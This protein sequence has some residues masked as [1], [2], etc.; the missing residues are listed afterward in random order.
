MTVPTRSE[1]NSIYSQDA[2][3]SRSEGTCFRHDLSHGEVQ[4]HLRETN[5]RLNS[6]DKTLC[7]V[8][9]NQ[10]ANLTKGTMKMNLGSDRAV[11]RS[12]CNAMSTGDVVQ[13]NGVRQASKLVRAYETTQGMA[14]LSPNG[15]G[16]TLNNDYGNL[17]MINPHTGRA[18][19]IK[20]YAK[21]Q[22]SR[23]LRGRG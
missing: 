14:E 8:A 6:Y 16:S 20:N 7:A 22:K 21:Q 15:Y 5:T 11:E 4:T 2:S 19:M 1:F 17:K 10:R 9:L 12:V 23:A 3:G 13:V 18:I